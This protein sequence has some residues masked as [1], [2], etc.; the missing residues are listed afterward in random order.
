MIWLLMLLCLLAGIGINALAEESVADE[1]LAADDSEEAYQYNLEKDKEFTW[2]AYEASREAAPENGIS[3]YAMSDLTEEQRNI[4][5]RAEEQANIAWTP[6]KNIKSWNNSRTFEAGVTYYGIPYGQPVYGAY[7]PWVASLSDFSKAVKDGSSKMYTQRSSYGGTEFPYYSS[8]CSSFVAWA[9]G[10]SYRQT[11]RSLAKFGT[12][13]SSL[14]QIQVG[15]ILLKEGVHTLLVEDV[16]YQNGT[17]V[18]VTTIEQTPPIILRT[19][20][21]G[22]S[23]KTLA[24]L[25]SAYLNKGYLIYR[26]K[27]VTDQNKNSS[28][29]SGGSSDTDTGSGT[30]VFYQAHQQ[31]YDWFVS[32]S[33]GE[34][35]GITGK[36]KRMEALKVKITNGGNGGVTYRAHCQ[37]YGWRDWVSD[38]QI[39]GTT[40]EAKRMEAVQIK[41]T[42]DLA[43]QYDIYYRVHSQTYGWLDW[44]K[45]GESAGTENCAK[46]MEAIEIRLVK[47]GGA[48]PG[49]TT[50]PFVKGTTGGGQL[51]PSLQY[52]AHQQTYGWFPAVKDGQEAG[53]TG[54]AK[55][56]EA[57]KINLL[58]GGDSTITYRAHCQT[59]GWMNWVTGGQ[60]AGTVGQAKRMEAVEIKLTG[61]AASQYD[62]YYRAHCQTYG[63]L[64]WAKNGESAG[65]E[66]CAKRLEA[67]E[68]KLVRKGGA[69]PGST[70]N[71][72]I[73][74]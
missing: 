68:I 17:L 29:I 42:G 21:G 49:K 71:R 27:K 20:W 22:K 35:A 61:Q 69:A 40:G 51:T 46:R 11:T 72:F 37:T 3:T 8:D 14:N 28:D 74:R 70:V 44:A 41:L 53:I 5:R 55:S 60:I 6:V 33:D 56:M 52:Q 16:K 48:A 38:W 10:L 45:N 9:W 58:N 31:T 13:V 63:W 26:S 43:N 24:N 47:K 54:R 12:R 4:V 66:G 32:V 19:V 50:R 64:G 15:D 34:E 2:E 36:A 62:I 18:S 67:I 59:Y 25:Q 1:S 23:A 57:L 73:K 65:T 7:V 39:A 30:H